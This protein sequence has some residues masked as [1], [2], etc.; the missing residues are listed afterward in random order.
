MAEQIAVIGAGQ[1]GNGIAHVFAQSGFPVTM[2]DVSSD[3]L[4]KGMATIEKN[5]DRQVK[6]GTLNE[7][8][9]E[10]TLGFISPET[11]IAAVA[12]AALIVE[13]ATEN[14]DLKF[15]I[16]GNLDRIAN[17]D[18]IL[19]SN[20]SS[21][22][23]TEIAARTKRPEK[24]V[25]MHFMNPVPVM[26]LVEIIR[27]LATSDETTRRVI[28]LS[29]QL[30]KTPVEVNDFPGFVSNRVLMPMINEAVYCLMEG[31][32][33]AGGDRQGDAAWNE[34]SDGTARSRRPH[35]TRHVRR[36]SRS[37][38]EWT[39]RSEVPSL[40]APQ[41]VRR[42]R[43]AGTQDGPRLLHVR[44]VKSDLLNLTPDQREI[45]SLAREFAL[46]EI[47]PFIAE[48]DE[49][50]HFEPSI[51]KKMGDLGLLGIEIPEEY[52]GMGLD[53][54]SGCIASE[55]SARDG[56]RARTAASASVRRRDRVAICLRNLAIDRP[57]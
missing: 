29:T 35:R 47:A 43:L 25:G 30:G 45:Q 52:G 34:S 28:D 24:V 7:K 37:P 39:R 11:D 15:K 31:V 38:S 40:F 57:L 14:T 18:A 4:E 51:V 17:T 22:S 5:L 49:Q 53:K 56:S 44:T 55:A 8:Q 42:R 1:M 9:R 48:W 54:V 2:V 36:D 32:G 27:G 50:A 41:E 20:T 46:N 6:K 26:K 3:A 10:E 12:D 33:K 21:I 23:I 19:A 16:F 13:A